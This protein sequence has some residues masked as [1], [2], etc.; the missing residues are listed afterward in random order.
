MLVDGNA[1]KPT[2]QYYF[3]NLFETSQINL[4]NIVSNS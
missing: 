2:A 4:K 3:E 1:V